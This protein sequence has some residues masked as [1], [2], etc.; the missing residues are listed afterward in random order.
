MALQSKLRERE[1]EWL[2]KE[3]AY[4]TKVKSL[5]DELALSK[6]SAHTSAASAP[7]TRYERYISLYRLLDK[8]TERD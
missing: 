8:A 2:K 1:A 6:A 5:E 7:S 4:D 3:Q